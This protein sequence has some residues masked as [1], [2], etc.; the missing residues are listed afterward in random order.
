MSAPTRTNEID[1]SAQVTLLFGDAEV[2]KRR[3]IDRISALSASGEEPGADLTVVEASEVASQ[4]D[5]RALLADLGALSLLASERIILIK[6]VDAMTTDDQR[7]VAQAL[8]RLPEGTKVIMTAGEETG[9]GKSRRPPVA[10][11]LAKVTKKLGQVREFSSPHERQLPQWTI[12]EAEQLGKKISPQA[13]EQLIELTGGSIDR[14]AAELEKIAL[15]VGETQVIDEVAVAAVTSVSQQATNFQLA[16]AIGNRDAPTALH[17]L[18]VLLPSTAARGA[19][20]PLVG[21]IARQLRLIWQIRALA[22][23]GVRLD[24]GQQVPAELAEMLPE[25]QCVIDAVGNRDWL[26]R[27]L[28]A[29]AHNFTDPQLARGLARVQQTD[30]ILKGQAE[31][32]IDDRLALETLIVEL[33]QL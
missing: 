22:R 27:K 11:E 10:A 15:Y 19:G 25:H 4:K 7:S 20:I 18:S 32:N 3:A 29:M 28:T 26:A 33:C 14:I 1:P 30:L 16:D 23:E 31:E 24:R 21:M 12:Q 13:A 9:K 6:R 2:L 8:E 17:A 5:L